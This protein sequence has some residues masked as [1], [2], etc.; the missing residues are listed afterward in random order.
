MMHL[1]Y[2][3]DHNAEDGILISILSVLK[4]DKEP[5]D[6]RL[7]TMRCATEE[8]TYEPLSEVFAA[9]CD[10]LVKE[11]NPQNFVRRHD[12]T[13][14]FRKERP[15]ANMHTRFSPYCMLR[16][17]ADE[18]PGMPSR[19]LYLDSDV[20]CRMNFRSMFDCDMGG[21][22]IAGVLDYYGRWFF[23]H[24]LRLFDYLNSGVLLIDL[25]AVKK[26]GLFARCRALCADRKLFLPDQSSLNLLAK[27]KKFLPGR[28]NDQRKLHRSTVL[29]HF[30]TSFR[31]FPWL[32]SVTVK[33][34]Q[35]DAVHEVLGIHEYDDILKAYKVHRANIAREGDV[36]Y[37]EA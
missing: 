10:R 22:E 7:F 12:L 5:L 32:H 11:T 24:Q 3:G 21:C 31:F 30:T 6:I 2:C 9:Y 26:S 29:Q 4:H 33:P 25:D 36:S 35:V 8:K 13:E 23:H 18:V 34:W 14:A 15:T 37:V 20:V 28:Y 17:F 1:L 16:L 27:D 19:I